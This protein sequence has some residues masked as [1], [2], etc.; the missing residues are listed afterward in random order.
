MLNSRYSEIELGEWYQSESPR[1]P[2]GKKI[3]GFCDE[4]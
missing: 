1:E 3:S 4:G 2:I